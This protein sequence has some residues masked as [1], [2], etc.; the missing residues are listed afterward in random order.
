MHGV[1]VVDKPKGPTSHDVVDAVRRAFRCKAGHT[2]TLDPMATGV[3]PVLLGKATR[4]MRFF[5]GAD[6]IYHATIQL[7]STTSTLDAEGEVLE[8]RPIPE[9]TP[10]ELEER[11]EAYR[12]PIQQVPPRFSALKVD[13]KRL[14]ERARDGEQFDVPARP[15]TI[16]SLRCLTFTGSQIELEI[17]CSSGTYVRSIARDLGEDLGCGGHLIGLRRLR[18]GEFGIERA[19]SLESPH[20]VWKEAVIPMEQLLL[21]F[22]RIELTELEFARIRNGNAIPAVKLPSADYFRLFFSNHLIALAEPR[23]IQLQPVLVLP[24]EIS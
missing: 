6:K 17:H 20:D 22:P 2:G 7:G 21:E 5:Q 11:L 24:T 15:V 13:G 18:A 23:Q 4:L 10:A 16:H 19:V 12:G 8:V 1:L 9:I 14:Y 3:L